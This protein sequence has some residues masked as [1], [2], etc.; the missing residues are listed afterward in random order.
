M[1]KDVEDG[2]ACIAGLHHIGYSCIAT[3]H[4]GASAG[5]QL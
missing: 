5:Q 1:D 2:A 4:G 3:V